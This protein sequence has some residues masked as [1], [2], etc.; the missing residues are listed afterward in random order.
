MVWPQDA[1][2]KKLQKEAHEHNESVIKEM[3]ENP[4]YKRRIEDGIPGLPTVF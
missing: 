2:L 3:Q 1:K 4:K